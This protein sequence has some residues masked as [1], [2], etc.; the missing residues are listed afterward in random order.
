LRGSQKSSGIPRPAAD[1]THADTPTNEDHGIVPMFIHA[2]ASSGACV[3][4]AATCAISCSITPA[5]VGFLIAARFN[6]VHVEESA[7]Q[8]E[9]FDF[10]PNRT[11]IGKW[12]LRNRGCAQIFCPM[13]F[14]YS[15]IA[16]NSR[17]SFDR[18][19]FLSYCLPLRILRLRGNNHPPKP[20]P[21]PPCVSDAF[22]SFCL[23]VV[24]SLLSRLR[25]DFGRSS[26]RVNPSG[27][28]A[29][30]RII[31]ASPSGGVAS[32]GRRLG[33]GSE[34]A[35]CLGPRLGFRTGSLVIRRLVAALVGSAL[36]GQTCSADLVCLLDPV[37]RYGGRSQQKC[38]E[39]LQPAESETIIKTPALD[40][41]GPT[42][43][44]YARSDVNSVTFR[45]L[46]AERADGLS[47]NAIRAR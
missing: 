34:V 16:G 7:R 18:F 46:D 33:C 40:P 41:P 45:C 24:F 12:N 36:A 13:R 47:A 19:H 1:R 32:V 29:F 27:V 39:R 6:P 30:G 11:L 43:K 20:A 5:S 44:L 17:I 31:L 25:D 37:L 21:P 2:H 4:R 42:A 26:C 15:L 10:V 8:G 22:T 3:W 14:T 9:R 28:V 38:E 23:R 35:G